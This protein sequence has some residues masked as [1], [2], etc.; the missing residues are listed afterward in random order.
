MKR[1]F[2]NTTPSQACRTSAGHGPSSTSTSTSMMPVARVTPATSTSGDSDEQP[3]IQPKHDYTIVE[4]EDPLILLADHRIQDAPYFGYF[5]PN[6]AVPEMVIIDQDLERI[7][8]AAKWEVWK[9]ACF[10]T[11]GHEDPCCVLKVLE[12]K[13]IAMIASRNI[14]MGE[15][16]HKER[17]AF[18]P[19]YSFPIL[20]M[21][22][23]YRPILVS[24]QTYNVAPDQGPKT[25]DFYRSALSRLG[26][27]QQKQ[28]LSLS[29][30]WG[31]S[32]DA[33]PG[34]LATNY[35]PVD[36]Q[37]GPHH[38]GRIY[39]GCFATLSRANHS[40]IPNAK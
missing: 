40:C 32:R 7:E 14:R 36:M 4:D 39:C 33:I 30:C 17:Y 34:I 8:D 2:F 12:G 25:G 20:F 13:G 23:P 28:I 26:R 1:G 27:Q 6:K 21:M 35:L 11:Q 24:I 22:Y 38:A 18:S 37:E 5:P 10:A 9:N 3:L 29:N 16:I 31:R 15:L 19:T